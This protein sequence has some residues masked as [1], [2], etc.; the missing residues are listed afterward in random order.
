MAGYIRSP[1]SVRGNARTGDRVGVGPSGSSARSDQGHLTRHPG[2][3]TLS[4][5]SPTL[6]VHEENN[7]MGNTIIQSKR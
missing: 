2:K 7:G 6:A 1:Y 3:S 4:P 5:G